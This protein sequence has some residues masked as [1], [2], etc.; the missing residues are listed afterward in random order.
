MLERPSPADP[1]SI[2]ALVA[3]DGLKPVD[4]RPPLVHYLRQVWRRRAFI[5]SYAQGRAYA[6][7]QDN[8]LGQLWTVINPLLNVGAYFLIF[9]LLLKTNRGVDNFLAFLTIG[10]FTFTFISAT[11]TLGSRSV[12][13]N[14]GLMRAVQFPRA[15]LPLASVITEVLLL[16]PAIVVLLVALPLLGE[17]ITWDW[18][19]LPAA[20]GLLIIFE[21]GLALVMA[22]LVS[23]SHDLDNL[24][25]VIMRLARYVSGV[26]FS[27]HSYAPDGVLGAVLQYQPLALFIDLIRS[28]LME[29]VAFHPLWWAAAGGWSILALIFGIVWFWR[30]E[31]SY[32]RG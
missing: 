25:P 9:G 21:A 15:A 7:N 4:S 11:L 31:G 8:L 24:V 29:E 23:T 10:V 32:G 22:R 2:A 14:Q 28:C 17:P 3:R 26:F 19:L 16:G 12:L 6:R 27:V 13:R 30:G 1:A 18:L 20:L 5:W